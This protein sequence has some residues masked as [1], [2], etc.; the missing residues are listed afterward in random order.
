MK[1]NIWSIIIPSVIT[2]IGFVVNYMLTI[3]GKK[4][5]VNRHKSEEQIK[6]LIDIPTELL[7]YID[8]SMKIVAEC[9][10]DQNKFRKA[11]KHIYDTILC[12]GSEDAVKILSHFEH[13]T[14]QK[15]DDRITV[16]N[17]EYFAPL[18]ILTMQIKYDIT[19]IATSPQA[20]YVKFMSQKLLE[21]GFYDKCLEETNRLVDLLELKSFLKITNNGIY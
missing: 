18:I 14:Y 19:N 6:K 15:V 20:W 4:L 2:V 10:V 1:D 21:T 16:E 12:Y 17:H 9:E 3:K 7:T 8:C 13:I 5:D 11:K